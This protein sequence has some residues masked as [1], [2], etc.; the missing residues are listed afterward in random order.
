M[1]FFPAAMYAM[2]APHSR[3]AVERDREWFRAAALTYLRDAGGDLVACEE[4]A[5]ILLALFDTYLASDSGVALVLVAHA[6]ARNPIGFTMAGE[7]PMGFRT[8]HGRAAMGWGTYVTPAHRRKGYSRLLRR[9]LDRRLREMG[10]DAILGG[11]APEN[12]PAEASLQGTGFQVY[13]V[14]GAKRLKE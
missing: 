4:N 11:Y 9:D 6:Y 10:F 14:L 13:Q 1:A 2:M 5:D 3:V 12:A 7:I 8:R